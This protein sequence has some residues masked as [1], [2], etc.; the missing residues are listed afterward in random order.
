MILGYK[1]TFCKKLSDLANPI[2]GESF[3]YRSFG[4]FTGF[5]ADPIRSIKEYDETCAERAEKITPNDTDITIQTKKAKLDT[6]AHTEKQVLNIVADSDNC[7]IFEK[8]THPVVA[9][10]LINCHDTKC[11]VENCKLR[12]FFNTKKNDYPDVIYQIFK[13]LSI[14]TL[15]VVFRSN[16]LSN[17]L[18]FL[19]DFRHCHNEVVNLYSIISLDKECASSC[20]SEKINALLKIQELPFVNFEKV[21][22]KLNDEI[23]VK[24]NESDL[25]ITEQFKFVSVGKHDITLHLSGNLPLN[26]FIELYNGIL[27]TLAK[28][29]NSSGILDSETVF[30]TA[31]I[32]IFEDVRVPDPLRKDDSESST[33]KYKWEPWQEK[34]KN[35]WHKLYHITGNNYKDSFPLL[36]K[37]SNMLWER[38]HR[39]AH[40]ASSEKFFVG[41][42]DFVGNFTQDIPRFLRKIHPTS[43]IK[44]PEIIIGNEIDNLING[45]DNVFSTSFRDFELAQKD[46]LCVHSGGKLMLAYRN[47]AELLGESF[48]KNLKLDE[49]EDKTE[50]YYSVVSQINKTT[51]ISYLKIPEG[52]RIPNR[53]YLT[54][55]IPYSDIY[56]PAF[57]IYKMAH[58]IG[59]LYTPHYNDLNTFLKTCKKFIQTQFFFS[60]EDWED[61]E[62][63]LKIFY[64][65]FNAD[66]FAIRILGLDNAYNVKVYS[67]ATPNNEKSVLYRKFYEG[68]LKSSQM[69]D[70]EYS[71]IPLLLRLKG[72]MDILNTEITDE[73]TLDNKLK[74]LTSDNAVS[75]ANYFMYDNGKQLMEVLK[76]TLLD[77]FPGAKTMASLHKLYKA[78]LIALR[79]EENYN[80]KTDKNITESIIIARKMLIISV[81]PTIA[82]TCYYRYQYNTKI[83]SVTELDLSVYDEKKQKR[84]KDFFDT[85]RDIFGKYISDNPPL[86]DV[87]YIKDEKRL[88][89]TFIKAF[90]QM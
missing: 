72:F 13:P 45:I 22:Q 77:F 76:E 35:N 70:T 51:E 57:C 44:M 26:R 10:T 69:I 21:V 54:I 31:N 83:K 63:H 30:L 78:G 66:M 14:E 16:K 1:L 62:L 15:V 71:D 65:D 27:N 42:R 50:I 52:D 85:Y 25:K 64:E 80:H 28:S 17:I 68:L 56:N 32:D 55:E 4:H 88:L 19:S 59:H 84:Y 34:F 49:G 90:T 12:D 6:L 33:D 36:F 3:D 48:K 74:K 9:V 87:E 53:N 18:D 5:F 61:L 47:F 58:E 11:S 89:D 38:T 23:T 82:V 43:E 81:I 86:Y 75:I 60:A 2:S 73:Q 79:N 41:F 39:I 67:N 46:A 20:E 7:D 8:H 29:I 37:F 24:F 40:T